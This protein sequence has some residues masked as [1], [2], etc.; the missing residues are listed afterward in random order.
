M[1]SSS[2]EVGL[3]I[4]SKASTYIKPKTMPMDKNEL[5]LLIEPTVDFG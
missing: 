3:A 4:D 2:Q 1:A 5:N